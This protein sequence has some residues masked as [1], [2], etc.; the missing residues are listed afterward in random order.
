M[1]CSNRACRVRALTCARCF[2]QHFEVRALVRACKLC[3]LKCSH[4]IVVL[5][6]CILKSSPLENSDNVSKRVF[7]FSDTVVGFVRV[8]LLENNKRFCLFVDV[9][10]THTHT[11][12]S[13][14]QGT[15]TCTNRPG[16]CKCAQRP[17]K[18]CH[19]CAVFMVIFDSGC[20]R[21]QALSLRNT[22]VLCHA[23][24]SQVIFV[25]VDLFSCYS[26]IMK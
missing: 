7:Q 18:R 26:E 9:T 11:H 24:Y 25:V 10:H 21:P 8:V 20:C 5:Q 4:L 15:L 2:G 16:M 19:G 23:P 17:C 14:W 13:L 12:I 22:V 3:G 1:H 6:F